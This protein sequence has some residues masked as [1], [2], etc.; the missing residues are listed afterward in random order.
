MA[1]VN[2]TDESFDKEVL[3]SEK[4]IVVDFWQNGVVHVNKLDQP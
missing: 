4:P 2:I 3:K 1:T